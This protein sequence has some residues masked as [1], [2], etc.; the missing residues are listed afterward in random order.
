MEEVDLEMNETRQVVDIKD[1]T[2]KS[3]KKNSMKSTTQENNE[4]VVPCCLRNEKINIRFIPRETGLVDN[5]NHILY[6]GMG[7]KSYRAFTVPILSSTRQFVNVLTND[8]KNYLEE[9]MGLEPNALSIYNKVDNFWKGRIVKLYKSNSPLD[10]SN[11]DDYINYKILLA[12]KT[13]IAPNLEALQD[14]RNKATYQFVLVSE[15]DEQKQANQNLTSGMRAIME[16]G[17]IKDDKDTLKLVVETIDGRPISPKTKLDF[18]QAQAYK[19]IQSNP[20]LFTS[21]AEDKLLST[22]VLLNK[23]VQCGVISKKGNYYYMKDNTPLCEEGEDPTL[24]VA[25]KYINM[26]KHQEIKLMLEAK[27]KELSE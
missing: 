1:I 16:F 20:R 12:N 15:S 8:E 21:V 4:D 19:L 11:P 22:K 2:G 23:A 24:N 3:R 25:A 9:I 14:D 5:P 18:I 7:E 17:R 10:L 27:T 13:F 26:P 6:G